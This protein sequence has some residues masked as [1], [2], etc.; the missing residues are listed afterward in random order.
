MGGRER[1]L[2]RQMLRVLCYYTCELNGKTF[3]LPVALLAR[4]VT[5]IVEP[6]T[7]LPVLPGNFTMVRA[8]AVR[9]GTPKHERHIFRDALVKRVNL[10]ARMDKYVMRIVLT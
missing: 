3:E 10:C 5:A 6:K 2:A 7:R 9:R 8:F 4:D 1:S